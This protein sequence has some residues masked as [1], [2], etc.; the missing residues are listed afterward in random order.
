MTH[1]SFFTGIAGFDLA[2]EW[3]GIENVFQVEL[4]KFCQKVLTKRF[5]N[6]K[7]YLDIKEFDGTEYRGKIDIISGGFPC[8]P[9]SVAGQ[10]KGTDDERHL[11]PEMLRVVSEIQPSWVIAENVYG[12]L[13]I[14]NGMV[15]EQVCASLENLGYEVQTF[16]IPALSVNAPH[17]RNR[18]WIIANNVHGDSREGRFIRKEHSTGNKRREKAKAPNPIGG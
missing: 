16:C 9:F 13:N 12:L 10:Q 11:F 1:G 15:F 17:K 18:I 14:Q 5:P 7:K 2:A 6:T 4:D 8:Q 3:A